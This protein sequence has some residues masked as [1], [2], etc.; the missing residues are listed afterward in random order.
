MIPFPNQHPSCDG[1]DARFKAVIMHFGSRGQNAIYGILWHQP[2][3]K[4][5]GL[6]RC[7]IRY[8]SKELKGFMV[9]GYIAVISDLQLVPE[10]PDLV[11]L[12]LK[13]SAELN[14][15]FTLFLS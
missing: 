15:M 7:D 12:I 5:E 3:P 9:R 14:R 6:L 11:V 8:I 10:T 1:L 4:D 2:R 13:K